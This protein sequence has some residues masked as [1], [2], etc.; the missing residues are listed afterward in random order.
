MQLKHNNILRIINNTGKYNILTGATHE[1][2]QS[3]W[4][5]MPHRFY[6][7]Q[8]DRFKP[9][10]FDQAPLPENHI[11]LPK[12]SSIP[13]DINID[14]LLSQNK[15]G[16]YQNIKPMSDR[17]GLPFIS[18]EHTLPVPTWNN[19]IRK[20]VRQMTGD[21]NVF[22]SEYS[23]KQWGFED[24]DNVEVIHHGVDTEKF[25]PKDVEK[26]GKICT[27][28]NDYINRDIFCGWNIYKQVVIDNNLDANPWGNTPGFSQPTKDVDHLISILQNASVFFN[29]STVSPIPT[30]LLEAMSVG[31]PCVS[32][33]T[34]MIPDIIEDGVNGF[35]SNDPSELR[36][37]LEW[38]LENEEESR[39]IGLNGRKT[40][41]KM[42][43]LD[44]HI[45]KWNNLFA[46]IAGRTSI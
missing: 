13:W 11:F 6:L 43:S 8:H 21:V 2:Y 35:I 10:G 7:M 25:V 24:V 34:C 1:R 41:E 30:A 28:V 5:T 20:S 44:D 4:Q 31:T 37:K 12:G 45:N 46:R 29:T 26:D 9:W 16:Q 15:F 38:C 17:F 33:S 42:F 14:I 36:S 18:L 39:K 3:N 23:V 19:K 27:I 32:T 40:I 22:I